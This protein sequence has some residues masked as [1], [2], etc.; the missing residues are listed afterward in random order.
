LDVT[1]SVEH[2]PLASGEDADLRWDTLSE[3]LVGRPVQSCAQ[4]DVV[5]L[6][7]FEGVSK[8]ALLDALAQDRLPA[9]PVVI[10]SCQPVDCGCALSDFSFVGHPMF[11][12]SHFVDDGSLWMLTLAADSPARRVGMALLSPTSGDT[13]SEV[14]VTDQTSQISVTAELPVLSVSA[15]AGLGLDW[16][17]LTVDGWGNP[18]EAHSLDAFALD[19]VAAGPDVVEQQLLSLSSISAER[20]TLSGAGGAAIQLSEMAGERP[21]PGVDASS[22]WV[23]TAWCSTCVLDLPRIAVLLTPE[24]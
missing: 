17:A 11:P 9:D 14:S 21:F 16:S 22:S 8:D 6:Y 12:S 4:V 2:S 19:R 3:D 13:T 5:K 20:W 10:W 7:R 24:D 15:D 23:F 18:L 1:L